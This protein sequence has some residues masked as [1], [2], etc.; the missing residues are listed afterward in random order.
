MTHTPA[1]PVFIGWLALVLLLKHDYWFAPPAWDTVMGVFPPAVFLFENDFDVAALLQ[2]GDWIQGGANVHSLSL[3][4][5]LIA[6]IMAIF[7][8]PVVVI[9]VLHGSTFLLTAFS[10]AWFS[11]LLQGFGVGRTNALLGALVLLACPLV[12]VQVERLYTEIPLM[13]CHVGAALLLQR[14]R[15]WSAVLVALLALTIKLTAIALVATLALVLMLELRRGLGPL[16]Y[17]VALVVGASLVLMLPALLGATQDFAGHWGDPALLVSQ[18]ELRLEAIPDITLLLRLTLL[19]AIWL[20]LYWWRQHSHAVSM[21]EPSPAAVLCLLTPLLFVAAVVIGAGRGSLFLPRYLVAVLPL[22]LAAVILLGHSLF[23]SWKRFDWLVPAV[24]AGAA[25]YFALN[26]DGR[27][28]APNT[29]SFSVVERSHAYRAFNAVKARALATL[30]ARPAGAPAYLTR[31]LYYMN[32]SRFMGYADPVYPDVFPVFS[33][34]WRGRSLEDFP[35][36]FVLLKG[37]AIHGGKVIDRLVTAAREEGGWSVEQQTLSEE[38]FTA[39]R[40]H[41][42]RQ[43][44]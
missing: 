40:F 10:L 29:S 42:R 14:K 4:T 34:P 9:A 43:L 3:Y 33:E 36:E 24:L 8:D 37:S 19:A 17:L 27:F 41:L 21:Q 12:L 2:Q 28:Y 30:E 13:A 23:S 18:L 16:K 7:R 32:S 26:H 11:S 31:E 6:T 20:P 25:V 38:G 15:N 1:W 35:D 39:D 22:A 5:W 44:R